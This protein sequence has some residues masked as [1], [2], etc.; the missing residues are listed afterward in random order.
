M[1]F[2]PEVFA[3]DVQTELVEQV[4]HV[5]GDAGAVDDVPPARPDRG[6]RPSPWGAMDRPRT[7]L[8]GVELERG[9]VGRPDEPGEVLD[10]ARLDVRIGVERDG[11][12]PGGPVAGAALLEEPLAVHAVGQPHHRERAVVEVGE[13]RRGHPGVVIDHLAFGEA[14]RG[15]QHLVEVGQPELAS[16]DL[17]VGL[18]T[19]AS[20]T[21]GPSG[22]D[23]R[24]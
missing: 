17:D 2:E 20:R 8:R 13:Q 22:H 16:A 21:F 15:V 4:A 1:P 10:R 12:E 11:L 9:E 24:R 18:R 6:R 3:D 5:E 19:R 23:L 14:G 7:G